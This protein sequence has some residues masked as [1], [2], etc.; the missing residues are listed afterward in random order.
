MKILNFRSL[1]VMKPE[2]D[3]LMG[4][5]AKQRRGRNLVILKHSSASIISKISNFINDEV[6][7]PR[8]RMM[9]RRENNSFALYHN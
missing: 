2:R 9:N 4:L 8:P 5:L 7:A 1:M 3:R 6:I